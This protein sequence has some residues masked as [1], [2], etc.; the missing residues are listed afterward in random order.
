MRRLSST[1]K[2]IISIAI[3]L[4]G[5]FLSGFL[6]MRNVTEFYSMLVKP[7]FS[8]PAWIFA[9]A[10][11]ILYVLMGIA[12]F[13]IWEKGLNIA[14]VIPALAIFLIQLAL[15][16]SWTPIFFGLQSIAGGF[17]VIVI[18]WIAVLITIILFWRLNKIAGLL[19]IPYLLWITF[20]TALNY[21][22]M[23]LN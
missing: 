18:L 15:N 4:I 19:L 22:I 5:G 7:S 6:A 11:T 9:P 12:A 23:K 21:F 3:P 17:I 13:L 20:A 10:W 2:L 8:P 16:F 1:E 14:G